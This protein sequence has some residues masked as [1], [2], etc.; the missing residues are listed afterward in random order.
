MEKFKGKIPHN[1]NLRRAERQWNEGPIHVAPFCCEVGTF[2]AALYRWENCAARMRS[3]P[4]AREWG[5]N[6]DVGAGCLGSRGQLLSTML[7]RG[8]TRVVGINNFA[9]LARLLSY[10]CIHEPIPKGSNAGRARKQR[11]E[12]TVQACCAPKLFTATWVYVV[13][14]VRVFADHLWKPDTSRRPSNIIINEE[15]N[16]FIL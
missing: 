7:S 10:R 3:L 4:Q 2:L 15:G 8:I 12:P 5:W 1:S 6:G 9:F 14:P 11:P 16:T 13:R